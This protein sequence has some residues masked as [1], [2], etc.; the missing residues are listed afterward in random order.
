MA[1]CADTQIAGMSQFKD[2]VNQ[3]FSTQAVC[4]LPRRSFIDEHQRSVK[5]QTR[6]HTKTQSYLER[7]DG[8]IAAVWI[9]YEIV[10][11]TPS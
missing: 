10:G 1:A 7:F 3:R 11:R 5:N 9:A 6:R 8:I 2:G 4:H